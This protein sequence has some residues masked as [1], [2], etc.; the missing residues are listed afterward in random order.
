MKQTYTRKEINRLIKIVQILFASTAVLLVLCIVLG[1]LLIK[2]SKS[3]NNVSSVLSSTSESTTVS[4][5][6]VSASETDTAAGSSSALSSSATSNKSSSSKA[7][8]NSSQKVS[9]KTSS[10]VQQVQA[11]NS[12]DW[13]LK[14]TN[15][16]YPLPANYSVNTKR[17]DSKYARDAGMVFDSRAV[18]YLNQMCAAAAKDNV[19][20]VVISAFRTR[21]RQTT[22]Y[23]NQVKKQRARYPSLSDAEI[24]AKAAT[25][26][27]YPGTSEHELGLAVDFN[28]VEES[29]ENS[30][31][32]KWLKAHAAEYGFILRYP[33][34]AQNITHVIYEPWHYRYVGKE[35]AQKINAL[36]CTLEEY[37]E[38]LGK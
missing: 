33:K 14:L 13:T 38:R 37:C 15:Y 36:G 25:V 1:I 8:A 30:T 22:L 5:T 28:S 31:Q 9:S 27:A 21:A 35:N 18:S 6:A 19:K 17:I 7:P 24:R 26:S 12:G 34:T 2:K 10:S 23:N 32:F 29:F 4:D 3:K 16:K 11:D 20:L